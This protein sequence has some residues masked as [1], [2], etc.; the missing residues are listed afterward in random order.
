MVGG[1]APFS[2]RTAKQIRARACGIVAPERYC[3]TRAAAATALAS[4]SGVQ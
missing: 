2:A 3:R 1:K 4:D